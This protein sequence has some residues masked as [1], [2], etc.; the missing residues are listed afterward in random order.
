ML[1]RVWYYFIKPLFV[2]CPSLTRTLPFPRYGFP[3]KVTAS[4]TI[5][6]CSRGL[7]N[8]RF[9]VK[10]EKFIKLFKEIVFKTRFY[11]KKITVKLYFKEAISL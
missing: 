8:D 7:L 9:H 2:I 11:L 5:Y 1:I 6:L 3:A 4:R 10:L